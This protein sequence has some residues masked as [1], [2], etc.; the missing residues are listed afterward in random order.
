MFRQR[1]A[2][3]SPPGSIKSPLKLTEVREVPSRIDATKTDI[4]VNNRSKVVIA[5]NN[6]FLWEVIKSK[7]EVYR[8]GVVVL[9]TLGSIPC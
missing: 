8:D 5:L 6:C 7:L 3:S 2:W 9:G 4:I 1:E